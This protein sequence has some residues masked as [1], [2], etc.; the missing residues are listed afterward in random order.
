MGHTLKLDIYYF[1]LKEIIETRESVGRGGEKRKYHKTKDKITNFGDFFSRIYAGKKRENYLK[2]FLQEF[3]SSFN[4]AFTS[5]KS[6]TQAISI[7]ENLYKSIYIE[8]NVISGEFIGGQTGID[9]DIY[10][11]N[12]A[13]T[14]K[15]TLDKDSVASLSYYYKIWLPL[16][17]NTGIIMIQSYTTFSCNTLF[18]EKL[19]NLFESKGYD[20][21]IARIVPEQYIKEYMNFGHIYK[22][23]ILTKQKTLHSI[24][25][26]FTPFKKAKRRILIDRILIPFR[27]LF[28]RKDYI[29]AIA[30]DVKQLYDEFDEKNDELILYYKDENG[31]KAHSKL[32]NIESML[33]NYVLDNNLKDPKT[34]KPLFE[35]LDKFTNGL[36]EKLKKEIGYTP[37][38]N[39]NI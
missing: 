18:K 14:K 31:R 23:L 13:T 25:P 20:L 28:S 10:K 36:R 26:N 24:N 3:V 29:H 21:K 35:E 8:K 32:C 27:E 7:T 33:P 22:I 6:N 16:D 2:L 37:I 11:T 34:Q 1:E 5:N 39:E 19:E 38:I 30:S 9:V 17:S 4:N 15:D 12:N